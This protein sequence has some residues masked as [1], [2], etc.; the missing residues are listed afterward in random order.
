[1]NEDNDHFM[2]GLK[3]SINLNITVYW[4]KLTE[5]E[6]VKGQYDVL[7]KLDLCNAKAQ[8]GMA[9]ALLNMSLKE[10]VG[11]PPCCYSI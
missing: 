7:P 2:E 10:E 6:S 8:L 11:R 9:Q 3:I 5:F 1:M 4:L